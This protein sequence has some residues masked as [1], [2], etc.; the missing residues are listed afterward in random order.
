MKSFPILVFSNNWPSS[1][2]GR[3]GREDGELHHHEALA[4]E[5]DQQME[6]TQD[7]GGLGQDDH[8]QFTLDEPLQESPGR[9]PLLLEH[10]VRIDGRADV[11]DLLPRHRRE[12]PIHGLQEIVG[13]LQALNE[14]RRVPIQTVGARMGS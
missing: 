9:L 11:D 2:N 13:R 3:I 7:Q 1:H 6:V 12:V 14:R 4:V 10:L 5:R 8:G